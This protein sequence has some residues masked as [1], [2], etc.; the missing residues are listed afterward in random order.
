M[1]K[2]KGKQVPLR[3]F[4]GGLVIKTLQSQC[5]GHGFHPWAGN[6]NPTC[7]GVWPKKIKINAR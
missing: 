2:E 5:K 1:I 4:P 7:D 6:W 3:D